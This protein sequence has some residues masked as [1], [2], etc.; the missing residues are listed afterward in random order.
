MMILVDEMG[1]GENLMGEMVQREGRQHMCRGRG[2]EKL[3]RAP[4]VGPSVVSMQAS[5]Q[6][7]NRWKASLSPLPIAQSQ[8]ENLI[9]L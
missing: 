9:F 5:K 8:L 1:R 4:I 6:A 2:D 3:L 7:D